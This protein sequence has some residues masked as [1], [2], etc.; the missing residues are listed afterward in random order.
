[1]RRAPC[2]YPLAAVV[3]LLSFSNH[4]TGQMTVTV[5]HPPGATESV[6]YAVSDGQQVGYAVYSGLRRAWLW[7]GLPGGSDLHPAGALWSTARGVSNGVQVGD[8]M[9]STPAGLDEAASL[10]QGTAGSWVNVTPAGATDAMLFAIDGNR[11]VGVAES[12]TEPKRARLWQSISSDCVLLHP[13]AEAGS[14]G[15]G[16]SGNQQVGNVDSNFV[17]RAAL[18]SGT[19]ESFIDLHPSGASSS[20]AM[21]TNGTEQVGQVN[22]G[23]SPEIWRRTAA[24]WRGS[25]TTFVD[26]NP[27]GSN[28]A[29]ARGIAGDWQVGWAR[30]GDR[31]AAGMWRGTAESWVDLGRYL[32]ADWSHTYAY[33]AS[34]DG[35]NLYVVG[36][37]LAPG[38]SSPRALMWT[39]NLSAPGPCDEID[40]NNDQ[41]LFDPQDIDAL[42]SVY[43]EGP[44]VPLEAMCNDLDFN[45]DGSMFDPCDIESFLTVFAEGP[46]TACGG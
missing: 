6:A 34:E 21:A 30:V 4:A 8:A 13:P 12:S 7:T 17:S 26:L 33:G 22:Y 20:T 18:W 32:P 1:M 19:P 28:W 40:F 42:L 45:N 43:S 3:A 29:D 46:C 11:Y 36:Y 2:R 31:Y 41:S 38:T 44:C 5:L 24:M 14:Y 39:W 35:M 10:W 15:V 9:F 25:A 27:R 16:I 23:F 37:G